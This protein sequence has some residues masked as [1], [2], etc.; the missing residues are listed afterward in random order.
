[1]ATISA[2]ALGV[3]QTPTL[4]DIPMD[5]I[6]LPAETTTIAAYTTAPTSANNYAIFIQSTGVF[7]G[8][9]EWDGT[10]AWSDETANLSIM[11]AATSTSLEASNS[12]SETVAR[13]GSGGSATYIVGGAMNWSVSVDGLLDLTT[14]GNGTATT[15]MDASIAKYYVIAKFH[16]GTNTYYVGQT[17]IDSISI[18]GGVDDIATYSCSLSGYGELY[19]YTAS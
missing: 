10:S 9:G 16:T 18:S 11:S 1:M 19:K 12:I 7:L 6:N 15:L 17:L 2:N 5:V 4:S 14:V 8:I 13:N 3:Y